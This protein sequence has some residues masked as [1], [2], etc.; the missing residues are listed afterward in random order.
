MAR[1]SSGGVAL[2][3][4]LSDLWMTSHLA[5]MGRM[6]VQG[7]SLAKYSAPCSVMRL[8]RSLMSMNALLT[9]VVFAFLDFELFTENFELQENRL[10]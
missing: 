9:N 7:L 5:V 8:G 3:C 4:V 1:S 6:N 10:K 2:H